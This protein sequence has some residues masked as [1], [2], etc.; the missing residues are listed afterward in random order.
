MVD[1]DHL[2]QNGRIVLVMLKD[3]RHLEGEL[4]TMSSRYEIGGE[5]FDEWEIE[6]L[7]DVT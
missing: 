6:T 2:P 3:G 7:E 1:D 5:T 4:Q